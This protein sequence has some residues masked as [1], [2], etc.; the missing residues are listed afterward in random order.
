[1]FGERIQQLDFSWDRQKDGRGQ[2]FFF[3]A[4]IYRVVNLVSLLSAFSNTKSRLVLQ[5]DNEFHIQLLISFMTQLCVKCQ[6]RPVTCTRIISKGE[7]GGKKFF[8]CLEQV[9]FI[10]FSVGILLKT[11]LGQP[12]KVLFIS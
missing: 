1:M 7:G 2:N 12:K 4:N 3:C 8:P 11:K 6:A 5:E 10:H 9:L